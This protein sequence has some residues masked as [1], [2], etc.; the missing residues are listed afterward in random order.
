MRGIKHDNV[1]AYELRLVQGYIYMLE[2]NT[3][4]FPT[5]PPPLTLPPVNSY[6]ELESKIQLL[7]V[8]ILPHLEKYKINR[9]LVD[10]G[11]FEF[12]QSLLT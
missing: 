7:G 3:D 1:P 9:N 8:H 12:L 10:N 6:E 4:T 11:H 2:K 5:L